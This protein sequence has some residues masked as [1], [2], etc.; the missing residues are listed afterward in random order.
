MERS[1][2]D[3]LLASDLPSVQVDFEPLICSSGHRLV[4][5]ESGLAAVKRFSDGYFDLAIVDL[6]L[7]ERD[8]YFVIRRIRELAE[9]NR[10]WTPI[11]LLGDATDYDAITLGLHHGADD[12][13]P[14]PY[15]RGIVSAKLDTFHRSINTY[16]RLI[17]SESLARAM[18]DGVIDAIVS[19]NVQGEILTANRAVEN[20]F[21]YTRQELIGS[22]VDQLMPEDFRHLHEAAMAN[23]LRSGQRKIIG[24][25]GREVPG[26]KKNG[27]T[28]LMRLG[29]SELVLADGRR[30]FIGVMSDISDLKRKEELLKNNTLELR[31]LNAE[32]TDDM[33]MAT[34][35]MA[36]MISRKALDED[37]QIRYYLK[38]AQQFSGDL[39]A[40]LR[41]PGG[42]LYL[43]IADAT[44][45]GLAAAVSVL[46]AI[47]V[48]FGMVPKSATVAEIAAEINKQLKKTI[49]VGRFVAAH[50]VSINNP[51]KTI[52]LWSGGMPSAWLIEH[53]TGVV[54]EFRSKHPALGILGNDQF[55]PSCH[56]IEWQQAGQLLMFSDGLTEA[57]SEQGEMLGEQP[58]QSMI[59]GKHGEQL[60]PK[61]CTLLHDH[62][63]ERPALDDI[64]IASV[65]LRA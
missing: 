21:G 14:K 64:S 25:P 49:P 31:R 56:I 11:L 44:G 8:G 23:Y 51:A 62:L 54:D 33:E 60:L 61:L 36:R 30:I 4:C 27:E 59:N 47:W 1:S 57:Q 42:E 29:V 35:V 65:M 50:L 48:F 46:P 18:S 32:I 53:E 58:V 16:H 39:I 34:Q 17:D 63:A 19:I 41:S 26:L 15:H 45:H 7:A 28:F 10:R 12:F 2:L 6:H 43:L 38:A 52:R 55:D 40:A 13:I 5:A 20:L 9:Q 22:N 3:I 37:P 24:M